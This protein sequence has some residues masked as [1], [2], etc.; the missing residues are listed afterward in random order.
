[1]NENLIGV[2]LPEFF[3]YN[4]SFLFNPYQGIGRAIIVDSRSLIVL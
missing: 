1:V 2:V 4:R 3:E